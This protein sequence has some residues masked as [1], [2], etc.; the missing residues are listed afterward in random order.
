MNMFNCDTVKQIK[1]TYVLVV[2]VFVLM[3]KDMKDVE[4][5]TLTT[6]TMLCE[7][8]ATSSN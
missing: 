1:Y 2:I 3:Q 4:S 6:A 7:K 8:W 5:V